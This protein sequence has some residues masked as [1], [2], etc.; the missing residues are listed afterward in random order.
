[1][2]VLQCSR[3]P[4]DLPSFP[5]RRSSDLLALEDLVRSGGIETYF[6]PV[7]DTLTFHRVGH[8]ILQAP[9]GDPALGRA[10]AENLRRS[11]RTSSMIGDID[12]S[13]R[14]TAL[15]TAEAAGLP[16]SI[17]LFL[18]SARYSVSTLVDLTLEPDRSFILQ[19]DANRAAS[20]PASVLRSVRSARSLGW[21]VV[22]SAVGADLRSASF[23]PLVSPSVV[24]LH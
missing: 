22:M 12:S 24:C 9:V 11:I 1:L 16:E 13:L 8:Q 18:I 17:R 19:L 21:G 15:R 4:R 6:T 3:P 7:V 23:V 5:T 14:D 20:S 10:E 2:S